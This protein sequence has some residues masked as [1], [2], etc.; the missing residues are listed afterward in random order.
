MPGATDLHDSI[1]ADD[2][3]R[4]RELLADCPGLVNSLEE[5]PPPIHWAIYLDRRVAVELLL[6]YGT[7]TELKDQDRDATPLDYAI[8]Y[9]RTEII[10][11]LAAHGANLDGR[12]QLAV[13]GASG[14]FEEFAELPGRQRYGEVAALLRELGAES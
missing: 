12:L 10:R 7:D 1:E 8:V 4:I 14:G 2:I 13:K 5:T 6:E 3:G 9:A 11:I